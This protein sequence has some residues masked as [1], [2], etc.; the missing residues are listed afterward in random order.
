MKERSLSLSLSLSFLSLFLF[1]HHL[2][3]YTSFD[4]QRN[5][6]IQQ[7]NK[8]EIGMNDIYNGIRLE[9]KNLE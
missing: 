9:K 4:M 6:H 1:H 5:I 8:Q 2:T 3:T 7:Q